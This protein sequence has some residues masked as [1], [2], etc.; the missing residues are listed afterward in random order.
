[1]SINLPYV[2]GASKKLRR[3]L[4]SYRI[5]STFYAEN[6]FRKLLYK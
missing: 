2:E 3:I 5:T 1:M 6:T 4:R